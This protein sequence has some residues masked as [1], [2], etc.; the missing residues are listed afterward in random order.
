MEFTVGLCFLFDYI[1]R[2]Y[3][4]PNRLTYLFSFF[5]IVDVLTIAPVFIQVFLVGFYNT[6]GDTT[7]THGDFSY[8]RLIRLMRLLRILR[9]LRIVRSAPESG[10][11]REIFLLVFT[12]FT[13]IFTTAGF[14]QVME[15][16]LRGV[17]DAVDFHQAFYFTLIS[18]VGRPRIESTTWRGTLVIIGVVAL[19]IIIIPQKLGELWEVLK[20]EN[21]YTRRRY[22]EQNF[23]PSHCIVAGAI[24]FSTL[25]VFLYEFY[26]EDRLSNPRDIVVFSEHEPDRRINELLDHP[27]Y[28]QMVSF[29]QGSVHSEYD[30]DRTCAH[31]AK[32]I[33]L[34]VDK[35]ASDHSFEDTRMISF[36]LALKNYFM[37][38]EK[39]L[40]VPRLCVQVLRRETQQQISRVLDEET[41]DTVVSV[42]TITSTL[43]A[44][45]TVNRGVPAV[46]MNLVSHV[47][48]GHLLSEDEDQWFTSYYQ[49]ATQ[50][51][52][53]VRF[54]QPSLQHTKSHPL[55]AS[56]L[57]S[58]LLP[59]ANGADGVFL[60]G[61]VDSLIGCSMTRAAHFLLF[62]YGV[63][64]FALQKSEQERLVLFPGRRDDVIEASDIGCVI[65]ENKQR[66][67]QISSLMQKV[68]CRR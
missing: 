64:L 58:R 3:L 57:Q 62:Q 55:R 20:H 59:L 16:G 41:N 26:H 31:S 36:V 33:F 51:M 18:T 34:F 27:A 67:N 2:F 53:T 47:D 63:V 61:I 19:S 32:A 60:S 30:L 13:L 52:Y 22:K 43:M 29:I 14:Y 17:A 54:T 39:C 46:V 56:L 65:T 12:A 28:N 15:E 35:N 49:G 21:I 9:A 40:S 24:D 7:H 38:S 68:I 1:L 50:E 25:N 42:D 45:N 4:A 8:L 66:L 10:L 44:L 48:R 11:W 6:S 37:T 23:A 5:A